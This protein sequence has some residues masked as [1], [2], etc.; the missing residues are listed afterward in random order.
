M[1]VSLSSIKSAFF[2]RRFCLR[3]QPALERRGG[4]LAEAP[5]DG[6][7][8]G[9]PVRLRKECDLA[10][11]RRLGNL[12]LADLHSHNRQLCICRLDS[13]HRCDFDEVHIGDSRSGPP[14][15]TETSTGD[16]A[17]ASAAESAAREE[18]EGISSTRPTTEALPGNKTERKAPEK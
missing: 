4:P 18:S 10:Q 13:L 12:F 15:P 8:G 5:S 6:L 1:K 3:V 2:F 11:V 7:G 17:S 9:A 16:S 14:A